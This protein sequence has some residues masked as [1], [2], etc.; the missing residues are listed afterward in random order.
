MKKVINITIGGVVFA[1]EQD[2][3]EVL[4]QYL[5]Q[6]KDNL[7]KSGDTN[8][9]LNDIEGA[10][11]EKFISNGR[12]EKFVVTPSD[13][14]GV[15]V[16]MGKPSDFNEGVAEK[17]VNDE[18]VSD[19]KKRLY[20]DPDDMLIAGVASGLARYF[21]ID[22]VLV[23]LAFVIFTF[24]NGLG[25]F[26][27][28]IMWLVVPVATTTKDKYAMR[29]E[30][31]TLKEITDRVKKNIENI[32]KTKYGT[33][34][35]LWNNLRGILDRLFRMMSVAVKSIAKILRVAIGVLVLVFGALGI[36]GAASIYSILLFSDKSFFPDEA[37]RALE[38][39]QGSA[40]GMV[41]LLSCFI[42]ISILAVAVITLG[43]SIVVK[44]NLFTLKKSVA[45]A[46]LWIVFTV[47]AV[48]TTT[49]QVYK[50]RE[51]YNGS[52]SNSVK[53]NIQ[54]DEVR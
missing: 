31:V 1:I 51:E 7:E 14:D 26:V 20:R 30:R 29:G 22:P 12:N 40:L 45:L 53:I 13:V 37:H 36:A 34:G 43:T 46:A 54:N 24:F 10:I 42:A 8:E 44:R 6:I 41:S 27:Y 4:S 19:T 32:D 49:L 11:A 16:E 28:L 33:G 52:Q 17:E 3:Y 15:I 38:M 2:A 47:V 25:I 35:G 21:D 23:R 39:L 50:I 48:S 9:I 5:S 18:P